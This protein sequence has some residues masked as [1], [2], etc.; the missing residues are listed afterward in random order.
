[1]SRSSPAEGRNTSTV[2]TRGG[3]Q[4]AT[5]SS[6]P[7]RVTVRLRVEVNNPNAEDRTVIAAT[8]RNGYSA[9]RSVANRVSEETT[10][11]KERLDATSIQRRCPVK[12]ANFS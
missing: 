8:A 3:A 9:G 11:R 5:F 1:M 12:Y 4:V 6:C 2:G 10:T 7:A